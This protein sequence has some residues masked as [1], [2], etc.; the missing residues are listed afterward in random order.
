MLDRKMSMPLGEAMASQRAIRRVKFDPIDDSIL[1]QLIEMGTRAPSAMNKQEWE[2]IVVTD[3]AVKEKLGKHNRFIWNMAKGALKRR[4]KTHPGFDKV[5]RATQWGV[6][7][8]EQYPAMIVACYRG[9][10][11][12]YPPVLASAF[13]G[14]IMPAIQNILLAAR[15]MGLGANL[16]NMPLTSNWNARRILGIP[17][18]ITPV[19]LI[20]LGEPTG[21]YGLN[22][23]KPVGDVVSFNRFG[24]RTYAGKTADD[25]L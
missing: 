24:N 20:T 21:K 9:S 14:S 17:F 13:Y 7:N 8:F 18:G 19:M 10:R 16:T 6:D 12:A 3:K 11:F 4:E 15:A 2:F 5:N 1:M 22:K 23:R 25:L